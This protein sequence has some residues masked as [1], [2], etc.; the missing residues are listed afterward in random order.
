MGNFLRA[1][2]G[3]IFH[4]E[5]SLIDVCGTG[6]VAKRLARL[7]QLYFSE[8]GTVDQSSPSLFEIPEKS[9]NKKLKN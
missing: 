5:M 8:F 9:I 4:V 2:G 1:P 3:G 7:L 6:F